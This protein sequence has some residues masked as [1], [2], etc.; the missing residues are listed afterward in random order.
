M[1]PAVPPIFPPQPSQFP[2]PAAHH[3]TP[4]IS[5]HYL[6]EDMGE[7][8]KYKVLLLDDE[9]VIRLAINAYLLGTEFTLTAVGTAEAAL[10]ALRRSNYDVV[11]SDIIM[12]PVDGF[13]FRSRMREFA[14]ELPI[15]FMTSAENDGDNQ[16][17]VRIMDDLFSYYLP[18]RGEA[19]LLLQKLRQVVKAFDM[20]QFFRQQQTII[21]RNRS[22]AGMVQQS[23]LPP[24]AHCGDGYEFAYMYRPLDKVSGDLLDFFPVSE[25]AALMF[26]GDVSGHG[27]HAGLVMAALQT[28][29][30]QTVDAAN[31][32]RPHEIARLVNRFLC[33][34]F[35]G[36]VYICAMIVYWDFRH[37]L[38]RMLNCG[39]PDLV[40]MAYPGSPA[41]RLKTDSHGSAIPLGMVAA[42]DY[43]RR[44]C[45]EHR[46]SDDS[47]FFAFT[48]GIMDQSRDT[49]GDGSMTTRQL[50]HIFHDAA[51]CDETALWS[52][53]YR[54]YDALLSGGYTHAQDDCT[55][56]VIR[57]QRPLPRGQLLKLIPADAEE[58]D[59]NIQAAAAFLK[60]SGCG[61]GACIQAELLLSEFLVN[62]YKH[63]LRSQTVRNDCTV[64][65]L[66]RLD[67]GE[68]Q[69]C[70]WERGRKWRHH[71]PENPSG[72]PD[73][74]LEE[75]SRS[76]ASNGRGIPIL[77]KI[78]SS[79]AT[80]SWCGLNKTIFRIPAGTAPAAEEAPG[81]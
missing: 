69:I 55:L 71:L 80:R 26:F 37:N 24:W 46:F 67:S 54:I 52:M 78:A 42:A 43:S 56:L 74:R 9:R 49:G 17:F 30:H 63:G 18:K 60:R 38:L 45:I 70:V 6:T 35:S 61:E 27:T 77:Q 8:R 32:Q 47:L 68:L 13:G 25:G 10:Q 33:A 57:K 16:L 3:H 12:S 39:M 28:Y 21:D 51:Y 64:L 23:L 75:L 44:D 19:T 48:D 29:L 15:I 20:R 2:A 72:S 7:D 5:E 79:I 41:R 65:Q 58:I 31:A 22:V 53:P 40:A 62:I 73:E 11:V 4:D 81:V 34:N 1:R 14:P 76:L 59:R 36:I 66:E 50:K